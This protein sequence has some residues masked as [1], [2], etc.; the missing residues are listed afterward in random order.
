MREETETFVE[1]QREEE[2]VS[3]DRR[4][5]IST[6]CFRAD[7][8]TY[9]LIWS[10]EGQRL[11]DDVLGIVAEFLKADHQDLSCANLNMASRSLRTQTM[12]TLWDTLF[13]PR[14][15]E[16]RSHNSLDEYKPFL[17][18]TLSAPGAK[19]IRYVNSHPSSWHWRQRDV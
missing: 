4:V 11:P 12:R 10:Q 15:L 6:V 9:L 5:I 1:R 16:E 14:F 19:Y 7:L 8:E 18:R 13:L 3:Q 2:Y 17:H